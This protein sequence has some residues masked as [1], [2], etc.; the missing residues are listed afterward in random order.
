MN[1]P[2]VATPAEAAATAGGAALVLEP[3]CEFLDAARLGSGALAAEPIGDGHSNLSFLLR[4]GEER[5]VLRRPP[6]GELAPSAN[7]VLREARVLAALAPTAV[8]VPA[9][10]ATCEDEAVIGAPFFVMSFAEGTVL[11]DELP[12]GFDAAGAPAQIAATTVDGLAA[13][14]AVDLDTTELGGFGKRAGYLERQLRRFASLLEHNATRALPQ[15]EQVHERLARHLPESLEATFVHG[16]YRLGNL[17]FAAPSRL[18]A[19]LDWE[20]ATVGDPLAD[21]GYLA[22]F[23]PEPGDAEN[24]MLALARVVRSPGFPGRDRLRARYAAATGRELGE[25]PWYEAMAIWK[26]AIFLEGSYGRYLEGKSTDRYFAGLKTGVPALAAAALERIGD[27]ES[28]GITT[29][30]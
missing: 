14:H 30:R 10:L 19:V 21:L 12:P 5:F 18:A 16:D 25:L 29:R 6:R 1:E 20:M 3:L 24:P 22:A 4:R 2:V 13:L 28:S 26:A 17:M 27:W 23:W 15:L 7:D 9:V 8:P 11:G